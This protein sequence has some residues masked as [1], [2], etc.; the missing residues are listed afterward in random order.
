MM[1]LKT[2]CTRYEMGSSRLPSATVIWDDFNQFAFDF[3][4]AREEQGYKDKD[5]QLMPTREY[6]EFVQ[7]WLENGD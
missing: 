6:L 7:E 5:L 2:S 1:N 3:Y 4:Q